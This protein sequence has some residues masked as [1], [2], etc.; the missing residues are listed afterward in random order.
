MSSSLEA[1]AR[2]PPDRTRDVV[3]PVRWRRCPGVALRGR[4]PHS[5]RGPS[6]SQPKR[7]SRLRFTIDNGPV[8]SRAAVV[9]VWAH[10]CVAP[11]RLLK[12]AIADRRG[13]HS[14]WHTR[15]PLCHGMPA[16]RRLSFARGETNIAVV[17]LCG[18]PP[19]SDDGDG[20]SVLGRT[21]CCWYLFRATARR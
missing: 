16:H 10:A 21:H 15:S 4:R 13:A 18:V 19:F 11:H 20:G 7:P 14:S 12:P 17:V 8:S 5:R 3:L 9:P 2:A 1:P 6:P